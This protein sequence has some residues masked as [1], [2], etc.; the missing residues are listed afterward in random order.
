MTK[1][2]RR[3]DAEF[4]VI[5]NATKQTHPAPAGLTA[6]QVQ[7]WHDV[8]AT[9]PSDWITRAA[10]PIL[11]NYCRHVARLDKLETLITESWC[12]EPRLKL[13]L[14]QARAE[15]KAMVACGRALRLTPQSRVHPKRGGNQ[16][17]GPRPWEPRE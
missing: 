4:G 13:L 10:H 1:P 11:T 9:V 14:T 2:G 12:D 16:P 17:S 7:V 15:C 6:T 8:V 3:S 5:I